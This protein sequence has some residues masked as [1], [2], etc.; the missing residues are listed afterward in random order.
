M[1]ELFAT[2]Q[3]R[4]LFFSALIEIKKQSLSTSR[5][6]SLMGVKEWSDLSSLRGIKAVKSG[7]LRFRGYGL[8]EEIRSINGCIICIQDRVR[9]SSWSDGNM[10]DPTLYRCDD[11]I[12]YV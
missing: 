5:F 9:R 12:K 8:Y 4:L 11:R 10:D 2:I 7:H 3:H 6:S 1:E